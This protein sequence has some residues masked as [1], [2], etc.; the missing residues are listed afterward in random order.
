MPG[1]AIPATSW[2]FTGA[3]IVLGILAVKNARDINRQ[4]HHEE[5]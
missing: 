2:L 1:W 4:K 3:T 5:N